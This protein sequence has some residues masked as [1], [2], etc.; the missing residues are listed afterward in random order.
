MCLNGTF[1]ISK[2]YKN[3][4]KPLAEKDTLVSVL[5]PFVIS[6]L[7]CKHTYCIKTNTAI[8]FRESFSSRKNQENRLRTYLNQQYT[9]KNGFLVSVASVVFPR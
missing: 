5:T 1:S 6:L 8:P 2:L 9:E 4:L 7:V 3:L